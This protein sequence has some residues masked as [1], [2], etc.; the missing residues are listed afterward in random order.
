[1]VAIAIAIAM[2][3]ETENNIHHPKL[4]ITLYLQTILPI[5]QINKT[6]HQW[7]Q[8]MKKQEQDD[9]PKLR[10]IYIYILKKKELSFCLYF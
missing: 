9:H 5:K 10:T 6:P 7:Q 1:M 8:N 4:E 3:E 2:L